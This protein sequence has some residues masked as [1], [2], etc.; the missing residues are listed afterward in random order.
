MKKLLS[1]KALLAF[2]G[3]ALWLTLGASLPWAD[4]LDPA[5]LHIGDGVAGICPTGGTGAGT[6][7]PSGA[8]GSG[9]C[10]VF[11]PLNLTTTGPYTLKELNELTIPGKL[12]VYKI[13]G[14]NDP[15]KNP[16][17]L[18]FGIPNF[19]L[20]TGLA[21]TSVMDAASVFDAHLYQPLLPGT[22]TQIP[23][24]FGSSG[25]Y[26]LGSYTQGS[27]LHPFTA[28]KTDW[29]GNAYKGNSDIYQYLGL[30]GDGSNNFTNW[31]NADTWV[32]FQLLGIF[33][34]GAPLTPISYSIYIY[35][36]GTALLDSGDAIDVDFLSCA[37]VFACGPNRLPIGSFAVAYGEGFSTEPNPFGTHFTQTGFQMPPPPQVSEPASWLL[38]GTGLVG[39]LGFARRKK[40]APTV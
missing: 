5:T 16:V 11:D 40:S 22:I 28:A 15:L 4:H 2:V 19:N 35:S 6:F 39:L 13:G 33:P 18:I 21:E 29:Q 25:A 12:D 9:S 8:P 3:V 36:L 34:T 23:V 32:P 7:P 1:G 24:G 38:L 17:L 37:V 20:F 10:W 31:S 14:G 26:G 30:K 27:P